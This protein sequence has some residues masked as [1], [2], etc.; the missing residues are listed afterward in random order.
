MQ[1]AG[2][3]EQHTT[4]ADN[5]RPFFD[6]EAT[7]IIKGIALFMMFV[8]HFFSFPAWWGKGIS[9]P[10][11]GKFA[12]YFS[13]P[14]KLCV[15]IFC[16]ITGYFYFFNK[17][18]TYKYSF[19]KIS[20]ILISYWCVFFIFAILAAVLTGYKYSFGD[21]LAECFALKY[22]T[23][24]FCWYINF[25]IVFMLLFPIIAKLLSRNIHLD[26]F[27]S[28]ILI[29]NIFRAVGHFVSNDMLCEMIEHQQLW[30]SCVLMGYVFADHG[31][32]EK[33]R[34]LNER[35]IKDKRLNTV[36]MIIAA[37]C[38]PYGRRAAPTLTLF[39]G[40]PPVFDI[41]MDVVYAP[42][43][44][45]AVVYL[46]SVIDFRSLKKPLIVIGKYSMLMWFMSC[47]FYGNCKTIFQPILYAPRNPILVTIWG[48][49]MCLSVSFVLDKAITKIQRCKNKLLHL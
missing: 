21:F 5:R 9:Y 2:F 6:K 47:V 17:H 24:I 46:C 12:P 34:L 3:P 49:I 4:R 14:L 48:H 35:I 25:Y 37:L 27:I 1:S 30:I 43:F 39:F 19:K 32:F 26:L 8:H 23:M 16:F 20:D 7:G 33:L 15:P 44:I 40:R 11:I 42:L 36:L 45:Y 31:L 38:L 28:L 10:L 41:S 13:A 29:P 22:P 18:K